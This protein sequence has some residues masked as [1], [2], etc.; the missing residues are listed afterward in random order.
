MEIP[1]SVRDLLW[2]Y[3]TEGCTIDERWENT[4]LERVMQRGGWEDMRWLVQTFDRRRMR[5]FLEDRGRRVLPPRELRYWAL[6]SGV[7]AEE[8]ESWVDEARRG[9]QT[10]RG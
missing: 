9:E 7:P 3:R 1:T 10:W 6:V 4:V 8:Q 5:S 2:E